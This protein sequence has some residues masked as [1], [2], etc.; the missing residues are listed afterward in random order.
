MVCPSG[1]AAGC[2]QCRSVGSRPRS[3]RQRR[4]SSPPTSMLA[5]ATFSHGSSAGG[6]SRYY[7][8]EVT[9]AEVRA[10]LGVETERQW[11]DKRILRT[12]PVLLGLF[13]SS[14]CGHDLSKSRKLKPRTAAWYPK[15]VLTFS[16]AIAAVRREI[17]P[18]RVVL[19]PQ[20]ILAVADLFSLPFVA[21]PSAAV[22]SIAG[23]RDRRQEVDPLGAFALHLVVAASLPAAG[24]H[25]RKPSRVQRDFHS[26]R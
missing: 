17:W 15:P 7:F 1:I 24:N 5:P 19:L 12:T 26:P 16:D 14:R 18:G 20:V 11:S 10:H 22:S 2:R 4:L 21:N 23:G 3:D 9:F 8:V 13:S 25:V 6:R